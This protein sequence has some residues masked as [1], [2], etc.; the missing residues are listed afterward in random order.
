M[1]T[2]YIKKLAREGKGSVATLEK[3][4]DEAKAKA[5]DEGR[6]DDYSYITGIFKNM[7]NASALK[8][9]L[10]IAR[11]TEHQVLS[12]AEEI[13]AAGYSVQEYQYTTLKEWL[14]DVKKIGLKVRKEPSKFVVHYSALDGVGNSPAVFNENADFPGKGFGRIPGRFFDRQGNPLRQSTTH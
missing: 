2:A 14:D 5:A 12:S 7:V 10:I 8:A 3:R 9:D 1:P 11:L 6:A 4:W 13:D